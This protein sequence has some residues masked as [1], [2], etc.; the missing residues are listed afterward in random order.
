MKTYLTE[1]GNILVAESGTKNWF[2][3]QKGTFLR[4]VE[5]S[6]CDF[7]ETVLPEVYSTAFILA[8]PDYSEYIGQKFKR[9][10]NL[11]KND[12]IYDLFW[13]HLPFESGHNCP[14]NFE[15]ET[16]DYTLEKEFIYNQG[17]MDSS[18]YYATA[19]N[20]VAAK[21]LYDNK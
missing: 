20:S 15:Y 7:L 5:D 4:F 13:M 17:I 21:L 10:Y 12:F 2:Q 6:E 16:K 14:D 11:A 3:T 18:N 1:N 8:K 19:K 9:G